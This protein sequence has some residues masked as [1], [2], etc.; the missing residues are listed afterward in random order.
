MSK[1]TVKVEETYT[2][3]ME[4]DATSEQEAYDYAEEEL[5]NGNLPMGDS[6]YQIIVED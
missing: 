2:W 1:Y 5:I 3:M 6:S 4:V